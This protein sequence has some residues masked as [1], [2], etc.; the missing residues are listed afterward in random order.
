MDRED[1]LNICLLNARSVR[2]KGTRISDYVIDHNVDLIMITETWLND[3]DPVV[4]GELLIPGYSFL[5]VPRISDTYGGGIG[6]L[7]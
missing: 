6:A 5:S 4:I 7:Y 1:Y 3:L 2:N